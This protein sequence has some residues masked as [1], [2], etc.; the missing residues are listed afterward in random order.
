VR[1]KARDAGTDHS[2]SLSYSAFVICLKQIIGDRSW[3]MRRASENGSGSSPI[4]EHAVDINTCPVGTV[5]VPRLPGS[6]PSS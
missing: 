2:V 4:T 5:S 1:T 6:S 3:Q